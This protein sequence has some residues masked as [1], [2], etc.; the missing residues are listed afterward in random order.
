[1]I[2]FDFP[3]SELDNKLAVPHYE[4]R[5]ILNNLSREFE[6]VSIGDC[7][8]VASGSYIPEYVSDGTPYLRVGNIGEFQFNLNDE[9]TEFVDPDHPDLTDRVFVEEGDVV[10]P[11]TG[12]LGNASI[13][14]HQ[15]VGAVMSQHV[16]RISFDG[17]D[18]YYAVAFLNT[19]FGK[20]QM[21]HSGHGSTR[22]ELTHKSLKRIEIPIVEDGIEDIA[23]SVREAMEAEHKANGK[24]EKALDL[25]REGIQIGIS[26]ELGS[27][28][29][30][31][32]TND[33]QDEKYFSFIP[34]HY[35]PEYRDVVR[36]IRANYKTKQLGDIAKINRGQGTTVDEYS[37]EGIPFVRPS[38][39]VNWEIDPYPDHYATLDTYEKFDQEVQENDILYSIEGKVGQ[40]AILLEDEKCVFKN[41]IERIRIQNE[42]VDPVFAFLFLNTEYGDYQVRTKK[43]IQTT[44]PGI[45]GRIREVYI[46]ISPADSDDFNE[47]IHEAISV[48][49][50]G[51]QLK[52]QK[53]DS[54]S[55]AK[56]KISKIL[57]DQIER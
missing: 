36:E 4:V 27:A 20:E 40:S 33:I 52:K 31:V 16:T 39:L 17:V 34:E 26:K 51:L 22:K 13:A 48:A 25:F 47:E 35:R 9:D 42:Q 45:A 54:L 8:K 7:A 29:F 24:L 46:P 14:T 28:S 55:S 32:R 5:N 6:T 41:H 2:S 11:R 1:M 23:Q 18:P 44:I 57:E 53:K 49:K 38:D 19:E 30:S 21:L 10:I 43:V 12:T 3:Q 15:T 56:T 37:T 50:E